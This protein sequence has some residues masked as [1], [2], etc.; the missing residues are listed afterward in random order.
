MKIIITQNKNKK[1][2]WRLVAN[3]GKTLA[4]SESYARRKDCRRTAYLVADSKPIEV[5]EEDLCT[6]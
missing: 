5:V 1:W 6:R 3:N 2:F 4:H